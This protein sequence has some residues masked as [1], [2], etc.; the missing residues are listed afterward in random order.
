[1]CI[2]TDTTHSLRIHFSPFG[3]PSAIGSASNIIR[4]H[5]IM[6]MSLLA[7]DSLV[8]HRFLLYQLN[9]YANRVCFCLG[10]WHHLAHARG[11]AR[12]TDEVVRS[13]RVECGSTRIG[14]PLDE[15]QRRLFGTHWIVAADDGEWIVFRI[16]VTIVVFSLWHLQRETNVVCNIC[17]AN[18][19][20][21][22]EPML[23]TYKVYA[24]CYLLVLLHVIKLISS[25]ALAA[26]D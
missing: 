2:V 8:R 1:M 10:S 13:T 16:Q 9:M 11:S 23:R 12:L 20:W 14:W 22:R 19:M 3:G 26:A 17:T 15:P 21:F 5:S 18:N 4:F 7:S 6:Q 24:L 25:L